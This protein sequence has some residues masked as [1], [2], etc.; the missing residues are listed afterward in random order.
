LRNET[1]RAT[2]DASYARSLQRRQL[3]LLADEAKGWRLHGI[4]LRGA[5]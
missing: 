4:N 2:D 1:R 3:R 5:A